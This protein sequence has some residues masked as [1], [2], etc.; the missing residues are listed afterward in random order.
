MMGRPMDVLLESFEQ[1]HRILKE[2][3]QVD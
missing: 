3:Q 2:Q 1:A